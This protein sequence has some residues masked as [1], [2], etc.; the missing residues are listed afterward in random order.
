MVELWLI[1]I[2][3]AAFF[4]YVGFRRGLIKEV[5]SMSG[6]V[7]GL[8]A[9]HQ[10]DTLMRQVLLIGLPREHQFYAQMAL[11]LGIV[12][13]AYQTRALVGADASR[14]RGGD[15]RDALQ[16]NVLGGI[17]GFING[18]LVSGSIWYFLDIGNY[19]LAPYIVNPPAGSASA[20]A[21]RN[22]PLYILAG[23]PDGPGDL[24]ALMVIVLFVIVLV[25]I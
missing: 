7:L 13:F 5:I 24:L 6:I 3:I 21:I 19:P 25:V 17:V 22:L 18:Y 12:F 20:E 1:V 9:L 10:F 23:G 14:A 11:F 15:G 16:S 2:L 4:A 8:F